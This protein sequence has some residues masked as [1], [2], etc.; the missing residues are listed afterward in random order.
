MLEANAIRRLQ[1][2][3]RIALAAIFLYA[4]AMKTVRGNGS[5]VPSTIFTEWSQSTF[6]RYLVVGGEAGLAAWLLA[7]V[8]VD[9]AG[10]VAMVTL[11]AFTGLIIF[12][13]QGDHPKPC[14]CTG[15]RLVAE[16]PGVIRSSLRAD[17]ARN[18]LMM[19]GAV[20]LYISA[21][22]RTRAAAASSKTSSKFAPS[23]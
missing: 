3:V 6:V 8:Q 10:I 1:I 13:F 20:W 12:E 18:I 14:G 7:G 9:A 4:A 21:E 19:S 5:Q 17:L 15:T 22:T 23:G 2:A 11:S 16:D